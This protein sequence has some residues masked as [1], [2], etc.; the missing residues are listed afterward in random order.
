LPW[1]RNQYR[2]L[3]WSSVRNFPIKVFAYCVTSNHTHVRVRSESETAVSQ[4]MQ[5]TEGEFA[6]SYNRRKARSGAFWGDRYHCTLEEF[7]AN[8]QALINTRLTKDAMARE[9]QWTESIAVGSRAFV[10]AIAPTITHRQRLNYSIVGESAWALREDLS[11]R[12]EEIKG[13]GLEA[14][15][16]R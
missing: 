4:W 7:R 8:Y 13:A 11:P 2:Q 14:R 15:M 6:Q 1:D 16:T 5:E 10:E 9:P 12:T 3:L